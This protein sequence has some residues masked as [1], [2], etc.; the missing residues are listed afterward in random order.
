M[1]T[2]Q[3][4]LASLP[5]KIASFLESIAQEWDGCLSESPGEEIDIGAALRASFTR[6]WASIALPGNHDVLGAASRVSHFLEQRAAS[7]GQDPNE[8]Q[9]INPG[10]LSEASLTVADLQCLLRHAETA[11]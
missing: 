6:R 11:L 3:S 7:R 1:T 5:P 10:S 8:I 2:Q 9:L 4:P